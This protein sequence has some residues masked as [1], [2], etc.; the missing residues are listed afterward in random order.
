MSDFER[1]L[2]PVC[3]YDRLDE[4]PWLD[5]A[6]SDAIC[7]SCGTHFGYDDAAGGDAS[8]R[9]AVHQT[10][11]RAWI[12]DGGRWFSVSRQ[13]PAGWDPVGQLRSFDES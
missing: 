5:G 13:P 3:G 2:C 8:T 6:P 11:R 7:P 1:F 10:L 9:V 4:P 12:S